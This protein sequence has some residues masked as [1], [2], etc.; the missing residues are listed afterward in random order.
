MNSKFK[1]GI[2]IILLLLLVGLT[3]IHMKNQ[4]VWNENYNLE[5][6]LKEALQ[7]SVK[8]YQNK[9]GEWVAEKKTLQGKI[10]NLTKENVELNDDQIELLQRI[11]NLNLKNRIINAALIKAE[12]RIDS[13]MNIESVATE[14]DTINKSIIFVN[15]TSNYFK[16]NLMVKNVIPSTPTVKPLIEFKT[17]V[18]PNKQFIE[19]H[20]DKNERK[21]YPISFS[22]TNSNPYYNVINIESYAIPQLQKKLIKLNGWEKFKRF[23]ITNGKYIF[24][25]V[26]GYGLGKTDFP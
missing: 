25:G 21:D 13:L 23:F 8:H 5:V 4:K 15:D 7:D 3:A 24:F 10:S 11:K 12:L 1:N 9:E 22:V 17:I 20:W 6:K 16:Y 19:F 18:F 14:I 2:I 26:A